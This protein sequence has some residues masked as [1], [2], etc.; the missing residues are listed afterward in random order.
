MRYCPR[1]TNKLAYV[2]GTGARG[3]K[4]VTGGSTVLNVCGTPVSGA[5]TITINSSTSS[6]TTSSSIVTIPLPGPTGPIG[7]A[8]LAGKD[9]LGFVWAGDWVTGHV[10]QAQ[11]EASSVP[12]ERTSDVVYHHG[13]S[14]ICILN[15]TSDSITEPQLEDFVGPTDWA[16]NWALVV[17][18]GESGLGSVELSFFDNLVNGVFDWIKNASVGELLLAGAAA[19]GVIW[20]GTKVI[21]SIF[22]SSGPGDGTGDGLA[23]QRFTG[24]DGYTSGGYTEPGP[25]GITIPAF[26]APDIKTV[27]SELCEYG[28]IPYDVASLPDEEC[29]LTIGQ[30]TSIRNILSTLS[31][32]YQF[33]MVDS[34][35]TLKFVP[36]TGTSVKTIPLSSIGYGKSSVSPVPYTSKRFQGIDL[37]RSVTLTYM[38]E[39]TDYNQF[40]QAS[41]LPTY[42]E[43]QDITLSVPVTLS[44][45]K[46]K[47]ISELALIQSHVERMQYKFTLTYNDLDLEP[48]DVITTTF[49]VVRITKINEIEE[50]LIEVE[51][52]DAGAMEA[53][54]SSNLEVTI[55]PASSNIPL[56]LGYSQAFWIDPGIMGDTDTG[57]RLYAAVHG[58]DRAGWPG[59][60][61][62]MSENSGSSYS[63]VGIA[64]EEATFGL[65]VSATPSADHYVWDNITSISVT[66]KTNEL[67]S[68]SEI[69]VLNGKNFCMIGQEVIGFKTA[70]LTAPK[71]YTLTGLLRGRRGTEQFV[72]THQANELFVLLDSNLV[73]IDLTDGDRNKTKSF[74]VVTIGS[75]L[76][77]VTSEDVQIVS[78]N[79]R[80]WTIRKPKVL[81][82]GNDYN[83]TW[84]E[85]VRYNNGL[86]DSAELIHD[87]DWAGYGI[88]IYDNTETT[89]IKTYTT[90]TESW[91]YTGA[92]QTTDFGS[93]QSSV[94]T[95]VVQLNKNGTPGYP[96]TINS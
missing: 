16:T 58:Y 47:E 41:Y 32:S 79:L 48:G 20:A 27:L 42:E 75:A 36:R 57:V 95:K 93:L 21:E 18:K 77:R 38:S 67:L 44:H 1:A 13:Q 60:Q 45:A 31:L 74:K 19:I 50:G 54:L 46:A 70:T 25:G 35:G 2:Y 53:V 37:P 89:I 96:T 90:Q 85:R 23:D 73:R 86:K 61:I 88:I 6:N 83:F 40:T 92:M 29:Q 34:A 84:G 62:F 26:V 43:G 17:K 81:K 68:V 7:P 55:P 24:S 80:L 52:T 82:V 9:G 91:T 33:E 4:S 51:C 76:D 66:L 11:D 63:T 10:Y 22:P 28:G 87:D 30:N 64:N 78:N 15:H 94:K 5:Y 59:A 14:W 65:V 56:T 39:D 3:T 72:G 8:G 12:E 71:T 49:G 69:D